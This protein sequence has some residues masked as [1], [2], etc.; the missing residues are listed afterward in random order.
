MQSCD[1]ALIIKKTYTGIPHFQ[2]I[3]CFIALMDT[4]FLAKLKVC[5][6]PTLQVYQHH[7]FPISYFF[8]VPVSKLGNLHNISNHAPAHIKD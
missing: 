8:I 5:G 4:V 2:Y 7:H 6:N 3:L 1:L